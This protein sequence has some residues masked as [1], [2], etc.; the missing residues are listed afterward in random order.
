MGTLIQIN[1]GVINH[2]C[3][4]LR[5][6]LDSYSPDYTF[7]DKSFFEITFFHS[8]RAKTNARYVWFPNA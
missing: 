1:F 3:C 2:P 8:L 5:N 7:K 6:M 4:F